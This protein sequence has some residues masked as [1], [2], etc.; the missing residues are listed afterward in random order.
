VNITRPIPITDLDSVDWWSAVSRH[1]FVCARCTDCKVWR[2]PA[3]A[4]CGACGSMTWE[5]QELTGN[6][7]IA[8][9][10]V[11]RHG[12]GGAFPLPSTVVLVRLAE[13][14]DLLLPGGWAGSADG[15][16]LSVGLSV[17]VG[18]E[19]IESEAG[20]SDHAVLSWGPRHG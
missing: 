16:D 12:F 15:V 8:S 20:D 6:G 1:E 19:D 4:I 2:W 10:I 13:Q 7:T 3:R 5:W 18:F 11:N 9:W 17:V 14:D